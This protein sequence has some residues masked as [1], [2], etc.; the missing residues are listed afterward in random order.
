M[1]GYES[2]APVD[3]RPGMGV[4]VAVEVV[5]SFHGLSLRAV[6]VRLYTSRIPPQLSIRE[7]FWI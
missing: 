2:G 6:D 3:L 7:R 5:L 4:E 1:R